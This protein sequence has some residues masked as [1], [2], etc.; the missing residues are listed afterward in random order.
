[1]EPAASFFLLRAFWACLYLS[2][3]V[4]SLLR[5]ILLEKTLVQLQMYA[6][7]CLLYCFL[8]KLGVFLVLLHFKPL[9]V[10]CCIELIHIFVCHTLPFSAYRNHSILDVSGLLNTVCQMAPYSLLKRRAN[11]IFSPLGRLCG[12]LLKLHAETSTNLLWT[13][14]WN[15]LRVFPERVCFYAP[16]ACCWLPKW[17]CV[18]SKKG[19]V[20]LKCACGLLC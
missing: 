4:S 9:G 14:P 11:V 17:S 16:G 15:I 1:M 8:P 2:D 7:M 10:C 6:Y 5:W 3:Y 20:S 12:T 19:F 18:S 13:S